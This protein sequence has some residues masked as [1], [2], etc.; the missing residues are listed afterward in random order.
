MCGIFDSASKSF[1][2]R[3]GDMLGIAEVKVFCWVAVAMLGSLL[4]RAC[5]RIMLN[6]GNLKSYLTHAS[7][8][9]P[10]LQSRLIRTSL[11]LRRW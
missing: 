3:T 9:Q 1:G 6:F 10:R 2:K 8:L 7:P 4:L 11:A 5:L